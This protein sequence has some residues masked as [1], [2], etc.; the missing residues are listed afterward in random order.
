MEERHRA[1]CEGAGDGVKLPR[2][3]WDT[4]SLQRLN[5]FTNLEALWISFRSFYGAQSPA[6]SHFS[7]VGEWGWKFPLSNQWVFIV[8]S[9]ILRLTRGLTLSHLNSANSGAMKGAAHKEQD[10]HHSENFK[11]FRSSLWGIGDKEQRLIYNNMSL[12]HSH[13]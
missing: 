4:P 10:T 3:L 5:V 12:Y 11:E 7:E 9:P 8:T 2:P 1:P 13:I 6:P